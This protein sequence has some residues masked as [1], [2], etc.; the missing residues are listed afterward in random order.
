MALGSPLVCGF[1][2]DL[3]QASQAAS[4]AH[5]ACLP[6]VF[7]P[8]SD[9]CVRNP[10]FLGLPHPTPSILGPFGH[11]LR[12]ALD[13]RQFS[14]SHTEPA[15]FHAGATRGIQEDIARTMNPGRKP[16]SFLCFGAHMG[17]VCECAEGHSPNGPTRSSHLG[18]GPTTP[19]TT[20][21]RRNHRGTSDIAHH[22]ARLRRY[23]CHTLG[24]STRNHRVGAVPK[25]TAHAETP[26]QTP[27]LPTPKRCRNKRSNTEK[28]AQTTDTRSEAM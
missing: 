8:S 25:P 19:H 16:E 20:Q 14:P 1:Q 24:A 18:S 12:L 22:G 3:Q 13:P 10:V 9:I 27:P 17:C 7:R 5:N 11:V 6:W 4:V 21:S 2:L 23:T 26:V 15:I 28:Q